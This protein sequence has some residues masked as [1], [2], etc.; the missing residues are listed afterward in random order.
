MVSPASPSTSST[1]WLVLALS[2]M[3]GLLVG[4]LVY[5][6]G[7]AFM[8]EGGPVEAA[9]AAFLVVAATLAA[10][11][12][13]WAPAALIGFLA[14]R[15]L[16]FDKSFL[17][18][19]ILQLRL[20]TGDAPLS[21]KA[22]GAAV[23]VAI[24]AT[25]WANLR[26]LRHWGAGLRPRASWAWIVLASIAIVVVAKTLDG[27][28]RKLADVGILISENA[29]GIASLIEEWLELGFAAGLVLAVLRYPR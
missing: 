14:L 7:A 24:L 10:L 11:R 3:A 1:N 8:K 22:I 20:Y 23:V 6:P 12:G 5:D 17:S 16:D 15:E 21:E 9:S 28:G 13:L 2:A 25:L 19:G 26:L 4:W 18:E 27:L 29:D